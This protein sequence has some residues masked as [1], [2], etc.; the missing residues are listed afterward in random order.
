M[1][2]KLDWRFEDEPAGK[3]DQEEHPTPR[4]RWAAWLGL[5]GLLLLLIGFGFRAWWRGRRAA[6]NQIEAEVQA[7]AR[8]ELRALTEGDMELYLDLQDSA[9]PAWQ[10]AQTAHATPNALLLPPLPN[11]T[12]GTVLSVENAYVAGDRAQVEVV[13]TVEL[14]SGKTAP[15]RAVRF[16]HRSDDGRWLHTS[17]DLDYAGHTVLFVGEQVEIAVFATDA[18]RMRL[19]TTELEVLAHQFCRLVSC[20]QHAPLA[21]VFTGVPDTTMQP[22]GVLPAPFL[23]GAPDDEAARTAWEAAL[24]DMLIDRLITREMDLPLD[25]ARGQTYK[26]ELFFARVR[27]WVR[28]E[29]G[30]RESVSPDLDLISE[31]LEAGEWISLEAL[32]AFKAADDTPQGPLAEAEIDLLLTFIEA[33]YG[34]PMV[35]NLLYAPREAPRM[36]PLIWDALHG[37]WPAFEWRFVVYAREAINQSFE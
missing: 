34:P 17:V 12:S 30:L 22:E 7:V 10:D 14:P 18:D 16:Y 3:T 35:T 20:R 37:G 31:A 5:S 36:E 2:V 26:G 25:S 4:R 6:L 28:A 15:F 24:R 8:L 13:C 32:W 29:L 9:D 21:L 1:G 27:E 11:L 19:I 23:V 33:E